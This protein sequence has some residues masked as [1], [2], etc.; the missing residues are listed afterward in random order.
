MTDE[1]GTEGAIVEDTT[2]ALEAVVSSQ[3]TASKRDYEA[4]AAEMGWTPKDQW[5]GNPDNWK[6]AE[7]YVK[8][9][10]DIVRITKSQLAKV[11][12]EA[13]EERKQFAERIARIEKMGEKTVE[14]LRASHAKELSDL[15]AQRREAVKAGDVE[16]VDQ[17]DEKIE[18]HREDGPEAEKPEDTK[19]VQEAWVAKQDW[20]E[21]DED[22]TAYAIGISQGILAK[23]PKITMAE[24]L[25]RTEE[26][27]KKKYP[28]KFG[29]KT[30][31]SANGHALVDGGGAFPGAGK[32]KKDPLATLPAEAKAQCQRDIAAGLYKDAAEWV[33]AYNT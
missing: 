19:A 11:E 29:L 17:L 13:A 6:D 28:E 32:P 20:W 8:H 5:K 15:K 30:P 1:Q 4:E 21:T 14:R 10:E 31:T 25:A 12:R 9:G 27:M 7:T 23:N 24:N 22:M 33:T 2:T 3:D 16:A 18:K 26:A